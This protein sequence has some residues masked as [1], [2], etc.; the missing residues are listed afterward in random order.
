MIGARCRPALHPNRVAAAVPTCG[1]SRELAVA[2]LPI[3]GSHPRPLSLLF[4]KLNYLEPSATHIVPFK[5]VVTAQFARQHGSKKLWPLFPVR[6]AAEFC[7]SEMDSPQ[8]L[9]MNI[10]IFCHLEV[11]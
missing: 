8:L 4:G 5:T 3:P 10:R 9:Q 11:D 7:I 6:V 1:A 2:T